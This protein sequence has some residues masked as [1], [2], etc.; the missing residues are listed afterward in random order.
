M[1]TKLQKIKEIAQERM[2][3]VESAH[4]F[5]HVM[6]VYNLCLRIAKAEKNVNLNILK[7]A[8]LLHDIARIHEDEDNSGK[9]DHAV[10][11]A[12]MAEKILDGLDYSEKTI[13]QIKHCVITHR[14]KGENEPKTIEAKILFDADKLDVLGAIGVA[15]SFTIAGRYNEK[16]YLDIP[17]EKYIKKNLVGGKV[18]G[19]IKDISKHTPN[20]EYELKL[21]HILD[22]LYTK[23]AKKIG[24]E[25]LI[26][27]QNFFERLKKEMDKEL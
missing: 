8:A 6:R 24:K 10:L 16:M 15:R 27:M 5:S 7:N 18:N 11:G 14:F 23:K 20:L 21:K 12:E 19:R 26:F 17:P 22:K 25:R 4:D 3:K 13:I 2:G 1:K 9:V